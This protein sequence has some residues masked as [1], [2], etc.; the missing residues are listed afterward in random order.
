MLAGA[1]PT[2]V[3]RVIEDCEAAGLIVTDVRGRNLHGIML[4]PAGEELLRSKGLVPD[5]PRR[6]LVDP[7]LVR[8]ERDFLA[9]LTTVADRARRYFDSD[10]IA[11]DPVRLRRDLILAVHSLIT[12]RTP[13]PDELA[14]EVGACRDVITRTADAF[15]RDPDS[16][17]V[18]D[19]DDAIMAVMDLRTLLIAARLA[20]DDPFE[21]GGDADSIERG[22]ASTDL[23][24]ATI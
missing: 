13:E 5:Q 11:D 16:L 12:P 2:Q 14:M 20:V 18:D 23:D 9:V 17:D 15:A 21:Q 6:Y 10:R 8:H 7:D 19:W 4:T 3:R 24:T 1:S 22:E